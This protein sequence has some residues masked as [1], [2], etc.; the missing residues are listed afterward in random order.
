MTVAST[1][2]HLRSYQSEAIDAVNTAWAE[3]MQRPAVV[4]PTGGG[5]AQP[6]DEP[7]LTP[8]GWVKIGAL[9]V[10]DEV[11]G[12]TG[13]PVRVTGVF[14]QGLRPTVTVRF[15]DNTEVRCDRDHLWSV[16]TRSM[17]YDAVRRGSKAW[18]TMTARELQESTQEWYVPVPGT[19]VYGPGE[20]LPIDPYT[21]GVLLG[22]GGLSV[23]GQVKVH[24]RHDIVPL[25]SVP[26]GHRVTLGHDQGVIGN[27]PIGSRVGRSPNLV[28]DALRAMGL[29]GHTAHGKFI[30]ERYLRSTPSERLELLRGILDTDG[31]ASRNSVDYASVSESL[32]DGVAEL[33][34]SLG[35]RCRVSRKQTTWTHLGVKKR[36]LAYRAYITMP[37]DVNPFRVPRKANARLGGQ[38]FDPVKKVASV[39]DGP[40]LECVCISVDATDHLYV[41]NG[42]TVTHNTVVFAHT[43]QRFIRGCGERAVVLV[44]RDEL[45][46]QAIAK[47]R[48]VAPELRVGKVKAADNDVAAQVAVCSIQTLAR[49]RRLGLLLDAQRSAGRVGL[50]IADEAHHASSR[51]W[52]AVMTALGCYA[53]ETG[54]KAVGV[55]ATMARGDGEGLG[56]TWEDVV[57]TKSILWMISK[58]YLVDVRGQS[59]ETSMD[60]SQVKRSGGDYQAKSLGSELLAAGGP[61]I[62]AKAMQTYAPDRR[63]VVFTP[64]VASAVA[65]TDALNAAGVRSA[66]VSGATPREERLSAYEAFRTGKIQALANC[67]VLVEGWDAPWADCVVVARPTQSAPLWQQMIGRGLRPYGQA[68]KDCLV[69]DL[70]GTGGRLSTLVDLAPGEVRDIR[71]GESLAEAYVRTEEEVNRRI[72]AKSL[73]FSLKNREMDMFAGSEHA[74]LRTNAGVLFL[75]GLG[76]EGKD[77]IVLWPSRTPGRWDVVRAPQRGAWERVK[78][79]LELGVAQAWGETIADDLMSF[80][81][82]RAASWRKTKPSPQQ[83]TFA[84]RLG[85]DVADGV[86]KGV[87]SDLIS[88]KV[89]SRKVDRFVPQDT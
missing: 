21:L 64:D 42:F 38:Q 35:G 37:R 28:M 32:V 30:P 2:I 22:D 50:V 36:G 29:H 25:L 27:Y 88:V 33:V 1:S 73:A 76:D 20:P 24:T 34:R 26:A 4:L 49:E 6:V 60:L 52:T 65:T 41:T 44:H 12:S 47:I 79:D 39:D 62:I 31:S 55:T 19:V 57:Y 13:R 45:A 17:K 59:I 61:D 16:Q 51:S 67:A 77:D 11:I 81:A 80:N 14:P 40:D 72:P 8:L 9:S 46:D 89:T 56:D 18:K 43:I 48:S 7:V 23:P 69:L 68:K 83:V 82:T 86:R 10:G 70:T 71:D 84:R 74:W 5:K 3:G 78:T 75:A 85:I 87:L 58:G 63:S 54:V 53:P 66:A 15:T